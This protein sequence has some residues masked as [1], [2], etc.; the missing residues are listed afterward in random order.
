MPLQLPNLD[1]R[2]YADLVEEARALIPTYAPEWT[3]HNP[4]DPGI[5][6]VELFAFLAEMLIYRLNR[7]TSKNVLSFLKLLNGPDW[8]PL[9]KNPEELTPAEIVEQIPITINRMRRLER[10]VSVE[11]FEILALR[12]DE[13]VARALCLPRLNMDVDLE[14]ERPGHVSVI[15]LSKPESEAEL[16]DIIKVVTDDLAG[17]EGDPDKPSK[18]LLTTRLHVVEPR[19]LTVEIK[20]TVRPLPDVEEQDAKKQA[21]EAV[22]SFLDPHTGGDNLRGW[23]FGRNVFVSEI[24]SLLDQL[25]GIDFVTKVEMKANT[26]DRQILNDDDELI[27]L[28]VKPYEL[29]EAQITEAD[30]EI[31]PES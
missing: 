4:S 10:A 14:R 11:D 6:I 28:E 20:A 12:A 21:V 3:N 13:R 22:K 15:V 24:F 2:R 1:D 26:S 16:S 19:Y 27:G 5:T 9:G 30:V 18:L 23:P 25:P 8:R 7:I 31:V 29:V 17:V